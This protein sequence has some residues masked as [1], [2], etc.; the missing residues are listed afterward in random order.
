MSSD[1]SSQIA[2]TT[3]TAWDALTRCIFNVVFGAAVLGTLLS[4]CYIWW[5]LVAVTTVGQGEYHPVTNSGRL[6]GI[7][8]VFIGMGLLGVL[9]GFPAN[10]YFS[11]GTGEVS[12]AMV[13]VYPNRQIDE[14][15]RLLNEQAKA[16][17]G[18]P[19]QLGAIKVLLGTFAV[20]IE[21][22]NQ[23]TDKQKFCSLPCEF[24]L[25]L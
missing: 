23:K 8:V 17:H 16:S 9:I 20:D 14:F 19:S 3:N 12:A 4:T 18:L 15:R 21:S 1:S 11:P 6:V 10:V 25:R 7:I 13:P 24:V 2:G 5:S 22:T